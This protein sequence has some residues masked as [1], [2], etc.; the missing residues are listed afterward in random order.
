MPLA[1][2]PSPPHA[3]VHLGPVTLRWQA[4]AVVAG[5]LLAIWLADRRYRKAG[6]PRGAMTEVAAWAVPAGL[7]PAAI[8]VLTAQANGGWQTVR[9]WD[10]VLGFPGA[11]ALGIL[12]AWLACRRLRAGQPQKTPGTQGAQASASASAGANEA[13]RPVVTIAP[14][15]TAAPIATLVKGGR[16]LR[17]GPVAAAAAPAIAFGLAVA[18]LGNWFAQQDFGHPSSLPWAVTIAPAHRPAGYENFATF[19]P[20]FLYQALWAAAA[21]VGVAV[22]TNRLSLRGDRALALYAAAYAAGGFALFWLG[23]GH[24]PVVFGLRAGELGDAAVLVGAAVY[25]V[26][27][28]PTR[29]KAYQPAHKSALESDSPVL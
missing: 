12:G 1:S 15:I 18:A 11:L 5:I 13:A 23:I 26:R 14:V 27:T 29:T 4:L 9:T 6:G 21:G 10:A 16:R 22:A 3:R 24:L 25:L 20:L 19:Q 8:G 28:R 7:I 2:I 17:F